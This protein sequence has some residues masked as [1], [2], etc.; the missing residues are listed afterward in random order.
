[1]KIHLINVWDR[2]VSG[3]WFVPLGMTL[4]MGIL[5]VGLSVLDIRTEFDPLVALFGIDMTPGA[6]QGLLT[7]IITAEVSLASIVFSVTILTLSIASSQFGPRLMRTFLTDV[8]TQIAL[9]A[10]VSTS[11]Y[12]LLVLVVVREDGDAAFVPHLSVLFALAAAVFGL[13]FLVYFI[14]RIAHLIQA[15]EVVESVAWDLDRAVIRLF[16]EVL[17]GPVEPVEPPAGPPDGECATVH[18]LRE[19]YL[20][21]VDALVLAQC[22]RQN[23]CV[24]RLLHRPGRYVVRGT[25]IAEAA[26]PTVNT[27]KLAKA[28]DAALVYG[29]RR[30]PRQDVE[31][32]IL[33]LAEV[34]VRALSPGINDPFTALNCI[35]RLSGGLARLAT[36]QPPN[37]CHHD[38]DGQLR[39]VLQPETFAS[40]LD[41]AFNQIRQ[42]GRE[43]VAILIRLLEALATIAP[44]ARRPEDLDALMRHGDMV[45]SAMERTIAEENDRTDIRERHDLLREVVAQA[46]AAE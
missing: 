46:R 37:P 3:F 32:T 11:V 30:T 42:Y 25:A 27:E 22:A 28:V 7:T 13:C 29:N 20:Q 36:R 14:H 18:A 12:C 23:D 2:L 8:Y 40:A 9:G 1:M 38:E 31:C 21:G 5:A 4:C 16:P 26:P 34:A 15:A 44:F 39:L 17:E 6:A 10:F 19:G 45:L 43:S 41:A 24:L 33:E 35:D